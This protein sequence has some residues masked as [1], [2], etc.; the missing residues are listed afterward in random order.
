MK[1]LACLL[2][3]TFC[4]TLSQA[5]EAK[6]P[7]VLFIAIDDLRDWV[8][9]LGQNKQSQT[10]N[11]DRL[12][13]MGTAFTRSYCAAPVCNPSRAALMTGMRPSTTGVYN[14]NNDW[15]TVVPED[16]PLTAAFRRAGYFVCGAGKIYHEAYARRSEWDDYLEKEGNGKGEKALSA[17]AKNDGVG[18]I[19]FAP[20]DCK[21]EDLPDYNITNYGIEQLQKA[22]DKPFF[23]AV[24]LHKPHM[25]WNVPQ[26]WYDKFPLEDIQL[27]PYKADDLADVPP[28]GVKMAKPEGDH[29]NIVDAGRWKEAIQGYLAAIAYT[30]MNI[31]R[32][33]DAFDKSPH[34]DN[35]IICFWCDHGWHLG[36]KDHWRKF[37]LWENTTRAPLLWAVP[38]MTKPGSVCERTVDFMSIYP[39]LMDLCGI[40]KPDHVE[41]RSIKALL[42][43]PTAAWDQPA[44]TTYMFNNHAVRNEGWRYIRYNN[45]DEELY[46]E[47]TDPNEWT[48][49]AADPQYAGTKA[50]LAKTM[51]KENRDDMGGKETD[52]AAKEKK[53][54]KKMKKGKLVK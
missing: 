40:P 2:A 48:N 11:I 38:G 10:P 4:S 6:R 28:S 24:G 43:N 20:L 36:E 3:L 25:P 35:T 26:K 53:K 1:F 46:N 45:G 44:M 5:A 18:G 16:K 51:P 30:D 14:N 15:R 13:K 32:L 41:G 8:G 50:E 39:T 19:K 17:S 22:H 47:L 23:L 21:D 52:P 37:A 7:N 31:G 9:Y 33:L 54:E 12:A 34:K 42:E 27:P 49:L 29:K